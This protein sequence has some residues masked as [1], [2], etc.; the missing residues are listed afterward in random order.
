MVGLDKMWP[1]MTDDDRLAGYLTYIN[2]T[3]SALLTL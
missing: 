1:I 3:I 2:N